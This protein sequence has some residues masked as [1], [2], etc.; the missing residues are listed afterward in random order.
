MKPQ[1]TI[2]FQ[3]RWGWAK[4]SK[5]YASEAERRGI[6]FA[7]VFILLHTEKN[8]TPSTRLGP[9]MGMESTSLSRS[10]KGL[11]ELGWIERKPDTQDGRIVRVFLTENGI[12]ARRQA[13]DLVIAV[14]AHLS[15][16]LGVESF[17]QMLADL[18]T[19]NEILDDPSLILHLNKINVGI[20]PQP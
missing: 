18:K 10:L 6:P 5:L 2:D 8:G 11:E 7:Y 19:L 20:P 9:K 15:Q 1:E 14:N 4:L 12:A 17:N 16:M 13:R 3:L